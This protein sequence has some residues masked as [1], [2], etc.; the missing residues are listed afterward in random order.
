MRLPRMTTRRWMVA[1]AIVGLVSGGTVESARRRQRFL[2]AYREQALAEYECSFKAQILIGTMAGKGS[3]PPPLS[4]VASLCGL[5]A[6]GRRLLE[7]DDAEDLP[8]M[9]SDAGWGNLRALPLRIDLNETMDEFGG[10]RL[11]VG[12]VRLLRGESYHRRMRMKYAHAARHPWLA[13]E[14]DPPEPE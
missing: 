2:R 11:A 1:V 3:N 4:E 6:E 7:E 12:L 5:D 13:V 10:D 9:M 14:A 8:A